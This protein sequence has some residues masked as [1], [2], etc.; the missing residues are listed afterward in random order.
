MYMAM[1]FQLCSKIEKQCLGISMS[2]FIEIIESGGI[3]NPEV[4][5]Y[6]MC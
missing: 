5:V 1:L 4:G 2:H 3:E 6:T